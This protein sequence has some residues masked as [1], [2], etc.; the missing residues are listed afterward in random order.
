MSRDGQAAGYRPE[1]SQPGDHDIGQPTTR[2]SATVKT[3]SKCGT[4][5]TLLNRDLTTGLCANCARQQSQD[6]KDA[7]KAAAQEKQRAEQHRQLEEAR[8]SHGIPQTYPDGCPDCGGVL[9]A[10]ALF[11][12]EEFNLRQ[13]LGVDAGVQYYSE[14]SN[15]QGFFTGRYSISGRLR[16]SMCSSCRRIFLHGVPD[17]GV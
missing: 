7:E 10:I 15:E 6:R 2:D 14:A 12:R 9:N 17:N 1:N 8:N 11:G 13:G 3:C 16:A 4:K 5:V